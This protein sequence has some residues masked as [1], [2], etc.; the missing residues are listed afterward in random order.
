MFYVIPLSGNILSI[1]TN[2]S[3]AAV[4][5]SKTVNYIIFVAMANKQKKNTAK[6]VKAEPKTADA[7][8]FKQ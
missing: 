1:I 3:I 2:L 6:K 4:L 7:K 8:P 5:I